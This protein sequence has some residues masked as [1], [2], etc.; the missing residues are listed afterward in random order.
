MDRKQPH[1][2]DNAIVVKNL[3]KSYKDLKVLHGIDFNVRR[4]SIL[5]LLGPNGAGKTTTIRILSTLLSPDSGEAYV[6]GFD[7]VKQACEVRGSIGLTGQFAAVDGYLTSEENLLM[8]GRLYRLSQSDTKQRTRELLEQFDLVDA[9]QRP[10]KTYSG[11]MKRRLDLAMSLIASPP[12]IFLDEPTTG[13]DPRSRLSMWALIKNLANSGTT[14][15]LTTQYMDEA[16]YL[17]DWIVVIDEGRVIA[18]G[19]ANALKARVGA[20]HVDLTISRNSSFSIAQ[21]AVDG[22]KIQA[23]PEQRVLT[24][25]ASHGVT[26]VKQVLQRL[27]DAQIEVESLSMRRPT[28]DDVFL[29]LTGNG[30][31]KTE[32]MEK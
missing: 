13:L 7:V 16:D 11:G 3:Q 17:A 9:A 23:N 8:L 32:E 20:D 30:A 26:T 4:G 2:T 10:V 25:A 12:V 6:N 19:D 27:E 18:E 21:Q 31:P 24:I 1:A 28:L 14:I 15:L 5:A 22:A 29:F